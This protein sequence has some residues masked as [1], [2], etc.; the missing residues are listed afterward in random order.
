MGCM[1][2]MFACSRRVRKSFTPVK[3]AIRI[4]TKGGYSSG[5]MMAVHCLGCESPPC[6]PSCPTG[7]LRKRKGGGIIL[8]KEL[9]NGCKKCL[10]GCPVKAIFWDADEKLP[11]FCIHCGN[12]VGFCPHGC[13][14]IGE[15]E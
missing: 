5:A 7:A 6:I 3:S 12:C 9:C 8:Q 11:I 14:E 4:K 2:C 15:I 13:L 1:S 10:E